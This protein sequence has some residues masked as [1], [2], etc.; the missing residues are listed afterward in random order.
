MSR[1]DCDFAHLAS[2]TGQLMSPGT[3]LSII[4][5]E[6][7]FWHTFD[8]GL[9]VF[10]KVI[11][12]LFFKVLT[13]VPFFLQWLSKVLGIESLWL[14]IYAFHLLVCSFHFRVA[15]VRWPLWSI[16]SLFI[17]AL[18]GVCRR[19]YGVNCD[20]ACFL[21]FVFHVKQ[22]WSN[23]CFA[24]LWDQPFC[25]FSPEWCFYPFLNLCK[26]S[27]INQKMIFFLFGYC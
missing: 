16:G 23:W 22:Q 27:L 15:L 20:W 12:N 3:H 21:H 1:F 7:I 2:V 19:R 14:S 5:L 13:M 6:M 18:V 8:T 26:N 11:F 17:L 9:H 10:F 25:V 4:F 24:S